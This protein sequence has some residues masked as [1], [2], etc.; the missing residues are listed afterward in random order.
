MYLFF[1][2]FLYFFLKKS[3]DSTPL[4]QKEKCSKK[5]SKNL[6]FL[7]GTQ[8]WKSLTLSLVGLLTKPTS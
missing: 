8:F 5:H 6:S 7:R 4:T 2:I 1:L 3:S